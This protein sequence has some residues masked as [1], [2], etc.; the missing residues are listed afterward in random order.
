[1]LRSGVKT[2]VLPMTTEEER[3]RIPQ[4]CSRVFWVPVICKMK[5]GRLCSMTNSYARAKVKYRAKRS[6]EKVHRVK[7]SST[8]YTVSRR[9]DR[10]RKEL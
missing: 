10:F 5:Q 4:N 6:R 7:D 2:S 8:L 3:L 1:M 9:V